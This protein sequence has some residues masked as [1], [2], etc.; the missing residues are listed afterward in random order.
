MADA[1][2]RALLARPQDSS[3]GILHTGQADLSL[4]P[5]RGSRSSG[6]LGH[7]D[8][9]NSA[10]NVYL[11]NVRGVGDDGTGTLTLTRYNN[12]IVKFYPSLSVPKN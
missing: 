10:P 7:Q 8:R 3:A 5:H 11:N 6:Q 2:Y 9:S 12:L 1:Y 4:P